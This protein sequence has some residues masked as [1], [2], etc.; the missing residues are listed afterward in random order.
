MIQ[1]VSNEWIN[2][3]DG[4]LIKIK[5]NGVGTTVNGGLQI[6]LGFNTTDFSSYG[7]Q[8]FSLVERT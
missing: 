2:K 1:L 7:S 4:L 6:F 5:T 8:V 3:S